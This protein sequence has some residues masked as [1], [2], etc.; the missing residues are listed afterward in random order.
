MA[1]TPPPQVPPSREHVAEALLHLARL[2]AA[3]AQRGVTFVSVAANGATEQQAAD[4][5]SVETLAEVVRLLRE[6]LERVRANVAKAMVR[7]VHDALTPIFRHAKT[8]DEVLES[9]EELAEAQLRTLGFTLTREQ[10]VAF[11]MTRKELHDLDGASQAA[12]HAI[13]AAAGL[14]TERAVYRDK[15]DARKQPPLPVAMNRWVPHGVVRKFVNELLD[16]EEERYRERPVLPLAALGAG[17][18]AG[19]VIARREHD[20]KEQLRRQLVAGREELKE[21]FRCLLSGEPPPTG[22]KLTPKQEEVWSRLQQDLAARNAQLVA[23][24]GNPAVLDALPGAF[25][26][27]FVDWIAEACELGVIHRSDDGQRS[28]VDPPGA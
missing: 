20:Y 4:P 10:V 13:G 11:I 1:Q 2:A 22:V 8:D 18:P 24:T 5:Q 7:Q 14:G 19:P 9:L 25:A 27:E 6:D 21:L 26:N 16:E 15:A 23:E 28:P 12:A 17:A 3:D